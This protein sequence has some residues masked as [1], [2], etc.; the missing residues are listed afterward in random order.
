MWDQE[1]QFLAFFV[2]LYVLIELRWIR[3]EFLLRVRI[4]PLLRAL[5]RQ[6]REMSIALNDFEDSQQNLRIIF[7]QCESTLH[8]LF[9]K[10]NGSEKK[11]VKE[12]V[13]ILK[14]Y[15]RPSWWINRQELSRNHAWRIYVDLQVVI[16]SVKYL[17]EDMKSG[18]SYGN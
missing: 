5:D 14:G 18:R 12:L 9:P 7:A 16:E 15:R 17:Q 4:A 2:S 10:L 6:A 13:K 1:P 8:N 11:M 3:K